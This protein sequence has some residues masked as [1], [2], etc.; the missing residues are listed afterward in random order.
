MA[1]TFREL[2]RFWNGQAGD[3]AHIADLPSDLGAQIGAKTE[4]VSIG[5]EYAKKLRH[6]HNLSAQ[7]FYLIQPAI[8]FGFCGLDR[9]DLVFLYDDRSIFQKM[10]K[11][12]IKTTP[13]GSEVWVKTFHKLEPEDTR[14]KINKITLIRDFQE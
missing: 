9:G 3:F 8:N 5:L 6:K 11:L 10:F 13:L 14:A 2:I 7:H 1:L 12:V 4:A